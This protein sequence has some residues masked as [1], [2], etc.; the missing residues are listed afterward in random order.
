MDHTG[1]PGVG[2]AA[3]AVQF[4]IARELLGSGVGIILE[5][6]FFMTHAELAG[7]SR[8]GQTAVIELHCELAELERR[9][10]ARIGVRHAGHRGLE[11]LPDLRRRVAEGEYGVPALDCPRLEVDTTHGCDPSESEV[12][13]WARHATAPP[14]APGYFRGSSG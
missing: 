3:F 9:Y 14:P 12:V 6:A 5:G 13:E 1:G 10:T 8:A 2:A 11:A 7:L 4:A